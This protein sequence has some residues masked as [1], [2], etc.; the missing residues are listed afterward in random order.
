VRVRFDYKGV[1]KTSRF[2]FGNKPTEK[3]AVETRQ[4]QTA[5]LRNVPVQGIV[6][7]E[8]NTDIPLYTV[9]D[10]ERDETVAYAPM[11][12][13]LTSDTIEDIVQFIMREE[14]RKI[15]ILEPEQICVSRFDAERFL[16]RANETM[17]QAANEI[18]KKAGSR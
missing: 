15:E 9:Y 17:R 12:V 3:I 6:I 10:E 1:I 11:E 4:Q 16:F 7:E 8:I 14:F 2:F 18:G 5:V 13:T